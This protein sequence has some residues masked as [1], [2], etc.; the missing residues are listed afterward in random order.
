MKQLIINSDD[1]GRTPD[2]SRGIREAHLNGV[3][4]ST[5]CMM[6]IPTTAADVAIALKGSPHLAMGVHLVLTMGRPIITR[7]AGSSIT[8]ENGNFFKYVPFV[9]Y[10]SQMNINEV[11]EE[12][13]AQIEAFIKASGRKPTHL[14]SHHHSSYFAPQL[15]RGMLEL[16]KEYNCAIRFP[17]TNN[18]SSE[19]E[20]TYKHVPNLI[21]EFN[22]R[23]P[24]TFL[25]DFYDE[26][27]TREELLR[28]INNAGDGATEIMCHPGYVDDAFAQESVY[29]FQREREL[30]ILT[31]PSIKK[32]IEANGIKLST[33]AEL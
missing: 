31:D 30:K 19:L 29:N 7:E 18:I 13:R 15:F 9:K 1:Y 5:T 14:D 11:K 32:A 28:L 24:D 12:W 25:V 4:T 27:A 16:A 8:D 6:N 22:P 10:L 20:E 2:I 26:G 17:F 23:R 33:F 21:K 3:V